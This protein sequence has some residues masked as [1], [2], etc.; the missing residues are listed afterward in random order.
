MTRPDAATVGRPLGS[1]ECRHGATADSGRAT[2]RDGTMHNMGGWLYSVPLAVGAVAVTDTWPPS[3]VSA[4]SR[5]EHVNVRQEGALLHTFR[6]A[7]ALP[8]GSSAHWIADGGRNG[9]S[10]SRLTGVA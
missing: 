3:C 1:A 2:A 8:Q 10:H 9:Q 4:S 7:L 5:Y 6:T